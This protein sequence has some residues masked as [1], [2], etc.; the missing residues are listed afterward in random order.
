MRD[1]ALLGLRVAG[2]A[3]GVVVVALTIASAVRTVVLPRAVP[4]RLTRIVFLGVRGLYRLRLGRAA[5]YETRDALM[6]SYAR[7]C[8]SCCRSGWRWCGSATA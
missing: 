4:S 2:F 7:P 3:V 1:A 6:A 8:S 5:D